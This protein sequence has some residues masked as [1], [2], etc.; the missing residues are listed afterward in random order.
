[1]KRILAST[2]ATIALGCLSFTSAQ[3][4]TQYTQY[5]MLLML[6]YDGTVTPGMQEELD[7]LTKERFIAF[8]KNCKLPMIGKGAVVK[9]PPLRRVVEALPPPVVYAP[10]APVRV[11]EECVEF[12]ISSPRPLT[13]TFLVW[14]TSPQ[15]PGCGLKYLGSCPEDCRHPQW[16]SPSGVYAVSGSRVLRVP[17]SMVEQV[18][19]SQ[20]CAFGQGFGHIN[21]GPGGWN[22][23]RNG[24]ASPVL[25][26]RED[27]NYRRTGQSGPSD[28][29][30][31]TMASVIPGFRG[32]DRQYDEPPRHSARRPG[33]GNTIGSALNGIARQAVG[34]IISPRQNRYAPPRPYYGQQP[35]YAPRP[36]YRPQSY[37]GGGYRGPV[38]L[39]GQ[40]RSAGYRGPMY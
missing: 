32:N 38:A 37:Y 10:P 6:C 12:E 21:M 19:S 13:L 30:P 4:Q 22:A 8:M 29:R 9:A 39:V 3:A 23:V 2:I 25:A 16:G 31:F 18:R 33:S 28:G 40:N 1:M 11:A 36:I 26:F 15:R 20:L 27:T 35:Y 17:R 7:E 14:G 24:K 5:E 34:A